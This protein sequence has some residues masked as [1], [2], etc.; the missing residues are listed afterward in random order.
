MMRL[1]LGAVPI[2]FQFGETVRQ[3]ILLSRDFDFRQGVQSLKPENARRI[4]ELY[5]QY[6]H[7]NDPPGDDPIAKGYR[8]RRLYRQIDGKASFRLI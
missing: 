2:D 1:A 3:V 6:H 7:P 4:Q 5:R 8:T